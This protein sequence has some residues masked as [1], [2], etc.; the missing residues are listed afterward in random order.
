MA[1]WAWGIALSVGI[2]CM[3]MP[4]SH[5]QVDVQVILEPAEIPYFKSSTL[6]I[7]VEAPT[8]TEVTL[9]DLR[10]TLKK[11]KLNENVAHVAD[12]RKEA[13][14]D[15]GRIRITESYTL[16]PIFV[17]DYTFEPITLTAGAE[18]FTVPG[19]TLRV[20]DLTEVEKIAVEEFNGEIVGG[21]SATSRPLT[22]RWEFWLSVI[23]I[24]VTVLAVAVYWWRTHR[25]LKSLGPEIDP[26][27]RALLRL[28][29]LS[30]KNLPKRGY[31]GTYYVDLSAILR[32]YIE[33]RFNINAPERTT[34]E[35]LSEMLEQNQF[36]TEQ[37]V[38]LKNFLRLC[39]RVKFAQHQ[40]G[41]IEMEES[42]IHV[43]KFVEDTIPEPELEVD[44][45]EA[46]A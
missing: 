28:D 9:P 25:H 26:W 30:N 23:L 22:Q 37:Q 17:Q 12:Y 29:A 18:T 8:N 34:E 24:L 19:P 33:G 11:L 35:F 45:D 4:T 16:E 31:Y 38:V 41:M 32:Y 42:F 15:T 1:K 21:P 6:R 10:D 3:A 44:I 46:A 2:L 14:G 13:L 36:T 5:A 40:P 27:D 43:R 20:R 39:D 7:V